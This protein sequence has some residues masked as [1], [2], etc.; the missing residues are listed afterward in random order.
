GPRTWSLSGS[1]KDVFAI[2]LPSM[3]RM[4]A[5]CFLP[6]DPAVAVVDNEIPAVSTM[7]RRPSRES[8]NPM[9]APWGL[10]RENETRMISFLAGR[11]Y[12][13]I[14]RRLSQPHIELK[15]GI[16]VIDNG[17]Q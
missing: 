2:G 14:G 8:R 12:Q 15:L 5:A 1:S 16:V 11:P 10:F 4:G 6:R 17:I 9:A 13:Q 7:I 3:G